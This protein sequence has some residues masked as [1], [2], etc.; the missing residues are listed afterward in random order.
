MSGSILG[1]GISGLKAFQRQLD[2]TSH[3]IAN[4]NTEGFS[5]QTVTL[6]ERDPILTGGGFQ[7]QGVD[8]TNIKRSYDQFLA[9]QVRS[10]LTTFHA[11]DQFQQLASQVDAILGNPNTNLSASLDNFF[12]AID[13]VA[14]DPTSLPAR[15]AMLSE[16]E[17]MTDRFGQISDRLDQLR[18][19]INQQLEGSVKDV[20]DLAQNLAELNV[21]IFTEQSRARTGVEANDLLDQR[22]RLL[23]QLSE[24]VNVQTIP[25]ANGMIN[26][27]LGNGQALVLD[28]QAMTFATQFSELTPNRLDVVQA[29]TGGNISSVIQSGQ[30]NGLIAFRDQ[31]LDPAQQQLGQIAAGIA[32]E[33]N[34]LQT[35]GFDLDGNSGQPLLRFSG[36]SEIPVIRA[37][38]NTGGATVN[39]VFEDLNVNPDAAKNL[40]FSD[41]ILENTDPVAGTFTLTRERDGQVI[42]LVDDGTGLLVGAGANDVLPGVAITVDVSGGTMALNDQFAIRPTFLAAQKLTV[43]IQDPRQIAAA[44]NIEVNPTTGQPIL[45]GSG[46]P[47]R[48]NGPMP[49][50]NR[51]A[52]T[53]ASLQ[54]KFSL[55]GGSGTFQDIYNRLV[56]DIGSQTRTAINNAT[57]Q[58]TLLTQAQQALS[59]VSGVNLDEEAANLIRFQ[60]AYQ[61]AAQTISIANSLFNDLLGAVR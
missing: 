18:N 59:E 43:A 36:D 41:F 24:L 58:E 54:N 47:V 50:D 12:N 23:N 44:T 15:T 31:I 13:D 45:D 5:R 61:A 38:G 17:A 42:N 57:A 11:S 20:N 1:I 19:Q 28:S 7:G 52:L 25:Q 60:Q 32:M 29:S 14:N 48:V 2:T 40:D 9:T 27:T 51:N 3:N 10:S 56:V 39:V 8:A 4:V 21:R 53:M 35:S 37:P 55:A 26:V 30:I 16:A 34:A 46:N 33:F 6:S 49:G 22:D